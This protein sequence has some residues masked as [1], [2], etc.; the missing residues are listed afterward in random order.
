LPQNAMLSG[1]AQ[2]RNQVIRLVVMAFG[3]SKGKNG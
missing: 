3:K 1:P 2:K